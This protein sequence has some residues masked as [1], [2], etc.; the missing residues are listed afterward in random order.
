MLDVVDTKDHKVCSLMIYM[1]RAV[2]YRVLGAEKNATI[3][4]KV[5][6]LATQAPFS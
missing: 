4:R 3:R 2:V 5:P 6:E 1:L